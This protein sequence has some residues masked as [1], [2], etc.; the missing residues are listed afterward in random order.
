M[1]E[2]N[3]LLVL[4]KKRENK[5]LR[6]QFLTQAYKTNKMSAYDAAMA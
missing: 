2:T 1:I 6:S 5:S 3:L 4:T